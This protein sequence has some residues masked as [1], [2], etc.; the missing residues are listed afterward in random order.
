[1][2]PPAPCGTPL[3]GEEDQRLSGS[4]GR[5]GLPQTCRRT[6]Y[7]GLV[8]TAVPGSGAGQVEQRGPREP[9]PAQ[10]AGARLG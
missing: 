3:R 6:A 1:M 2:R 5:R 8:R 9:A 10:C 4:L 7:L